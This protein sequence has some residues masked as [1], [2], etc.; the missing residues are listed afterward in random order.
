MENIIQTL[1]KI[2]Q[3]L[4]ATPEEEN[5]TSLQYSGINKENTC[6]NNNVGSIAQLL[7]AHNGKCVFI[8]P[9][10]LHS[11]KNQMSISSSGEVESIYEKYT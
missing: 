10:I 9:D 2:I 3:T 11:A 6:N 4:C 5:N 8:H 7:E 1:K